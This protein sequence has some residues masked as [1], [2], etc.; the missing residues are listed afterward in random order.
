M[1]DAFFDSNVLLYLIGERDKAARARELLVSGG[2]VSVQVLNECASVARGKFSLDWDE[3]RLMIEGISFSCKVRPVS[4]DVHLIGLDIAQRYGYSVYDSMIIAAALEAGC[5]TLY[6][7]DM[8]HGQKI[9]GLAI[10][11]PFKPH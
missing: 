7:E 6:S 3:I 11:N 5:T 8:Q 10:R 9:E 1:A 2:T 4:L